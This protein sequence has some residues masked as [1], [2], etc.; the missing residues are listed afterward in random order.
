M[1]NDYQRR[2]FQQVTPALATPLKKDGTVDTKGLAELVRYV[3]GK[4]MKTIFVL[5][6]A[7]EVLAFSREERREIIQTAREAAGKDTLLIAGTMDDSTHL[8]LQ[9]MRDAKEMG[10]DLALTTPPNFVHCTE[11][12]LESFFLELA[13]E[14]PIPYIIYNCPENQHYLEASVLNRLLTHPNIVG[15]KETSNAAKIQQLILHLDKE[16]D[17]VVMSGEEFVYYPAMA[18][19]VE[20]FIMGGPGNILPAQSIE[21]FEKYKHGEVQEARDLYLKMIGFLSEL[22]YTLPYPTM[23]PQIK[24]VLEIWGI[25]GRWMAKPTASV[26]EEDM[27]K[28]EGLLKKYHIEK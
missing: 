20:A 1:Y 4:G 28:I 10:A 5:G 3:M 9:H 23:M 25:C 26:S 11:A 22:Y 16:L 12:E 2:L 27:K 8:V 17:T 15:L 24:A 6:Y 14:S 21:I 13:D 7:G 19:G 18:L